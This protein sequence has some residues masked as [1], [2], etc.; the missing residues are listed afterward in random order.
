MNHP[1]IFNNNS[2]KEIAQII[3]DEFVKDNS[4]SKNNV[5]KRID[6]FE[7]SFWSKHQIEEEL[8]EPKLLERKWEISDI[9][10]EKILQLEMELEL[11]ENDL[12]T[13]KSDEEIAEMIFNKVKKQTDLS[14]V[15][16][17]LY[18]SEIGVENIFNFPQ[19]TYYRWEKIN[20][21]VWQR[22]KM[23]K[24]QRKHEKIERERNDAFNYINE[25]IEWVK[26]K[27]L[28]KLSKINLKLYLSEKKMDLAPVNRQALY[29]EVN[30]EI[31]SKKEKI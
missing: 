18:W 5:R 30:K 31:E 10:M 2:N 24:N 4:L 26:D 12:L 21:M 15:N 14:F 6:I 17:N 25:I 20:N 28:K 1:N 22:T 19:S 3:Y 16:L 9:V 11:K 27:G 23:L 29:L 13:T 8:L 7:E